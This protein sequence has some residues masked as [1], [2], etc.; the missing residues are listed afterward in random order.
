MDFKKKYL[1]YKNKYLN[2]KGGSNDALNNNTKTNNI[3]KFSNN[4]MTN[5]QFTITSKL[6]ANNK[7]ELKPINSSHTYKITINNFTDKTYSDLMSLLEKIKSRLGKFSDENDDITVDSFIPPL[8]QSSNDQ[9]PPVE[10]IKIHSPPQ[11]YNETTSTSL[12][13]TLNITRIY[14]NPIINT[15]IVSPSSNLNN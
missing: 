2:Q 1:K 4:L 8:S 9:Q 3:I 13:D 11:N 5:G 10:T 6:D 12:K 7:L 15:T 14:P